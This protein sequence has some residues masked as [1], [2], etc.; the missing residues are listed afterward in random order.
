MNKLNLNFILIL[1]VFCLAISC[2]SN[3]EEGTT[4]SN[5]REPLDDEEI[6]SLEKGV[7]SFY[8][9]ES[10]LVLKSRSEWESHYALTRESEFDKSNAP[11]VDF[12]K[13]Y[14]VAVH[15]GSSKRGTSVEIYQV[16]FDTT[17]STMQVKYK[18]VINSNQ[19]NENSFVEP[20]HFVR[21]N[22]KN[23]EYRF[24]LTGTETL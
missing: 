13:E 15:L 10:F 17:E 24:I 4:A 9:A 19:V 12:S 2:S 7:V 22:Q 21:V 5:S 8:K 16:S 3:G 23:L 1:F 18:K 20:Y 14:V 11:L 6:A